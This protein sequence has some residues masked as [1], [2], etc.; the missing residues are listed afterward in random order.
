M[1][2]SPWPDTCGRSTCGSPPVRLLASMPTAVGS[3][4]VA[5]DELHRVVYTQDQKPFDA[6]LY[7]FPHPK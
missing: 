7:A 3:H 2:L 1:C 6:G 4:S 5:F